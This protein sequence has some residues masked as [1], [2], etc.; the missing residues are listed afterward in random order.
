MSTRE[1]SFFGAPERRRLEG[2]DVEWF[3]PTEHSRGP[4]DPDGCHAGPP[5]GLLVRAMEHALPAVRLTRI[6]VDLAKPIPMA[7]FGVDV[8]VTR[9]GRTVAGSCARIVD[10]EGIVR[11]TAVG[12]HV[13]VSAEPVL[14][15]TLDNS[16]IVTPRLADS[17]PGAFPIARLHH[18]LASFSGSAV[19]MRYPA[20]DGPEPGVDHGLDEHRPAAVR[21]GALAVPADLPARRLWQCLQRATVDPDEMQ[22][23][24]ADLTVVL[25]R[26]PVGE[27]LGS[28]AVAQWQPS[29]I[30]LADAVLF[31]D[32]GAVGS[33]PADARAA[34]GPARAYDPSSKPRSVAMSNGW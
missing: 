11:A 3:T 1:E 14:D 8:E 6:T 23:V 22:F 31:D 4:W 9:S 21:R 33:R 24:N 34:P 27:W 30:G 17:A 32:H 13:A 18:G 26:D 7:G 15:M 12:L 28:R 29:G 20:G 25:H 10:G 19:R 16:G 2:R 5:T